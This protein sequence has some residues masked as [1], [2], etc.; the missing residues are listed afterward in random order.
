MFG[1]TSWSPSWYELRYCQEVNYLKK[2]NKKTT[3]T[4]PHKPIG[5]CIRS[6]TG[7]WQCTLI[8]APLGYLRH[9]HNCYITHSVALSGPWASHSL[10]YH[11]NAQVTATVLHCKSCAW[12]TRLSNPWVPVG[13]PGRREYCWV[14]FNSSINNHFG[15]QII[16]NNII[17]N[18]AY[19]ICHIIKHI[20]SIINAQLKE[21]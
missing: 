8:V 6:G 21:Y 9:Q 18:K 11:I 4:K 10:P 2:Q 12:L 16:C 3:T 13:H 5:S 19:Y 1:V 20:I 7:L 14:P 17:C 15:G